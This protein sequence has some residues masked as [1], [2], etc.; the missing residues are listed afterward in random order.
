MKTK[1]PT[2]LSVGTLIVALA[3]ASPAL[4][5]KGSF[6]L[7]LGAGLTILDDKLG[8]DTGLSG[9]FRAGYYFT[10]RFEVEVQHTYASSVVDGAFTSDTLNAVYY[11]PNDEGS[12]PY[13]LVGAGI[14]DVELDALFVDSETDEGTAIRAAAGI[15]FGRDAWQRAFFRAELSALAE[16]SFDENSTHLSAM[17]LFGWN[18]GS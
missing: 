10:D 18:F 5:Q 1:T 3:A 2:L 7:G 4:A 17:V 14:A 13:L 15:R 9:D 12:L 6:E 16:D 8:G 11:F